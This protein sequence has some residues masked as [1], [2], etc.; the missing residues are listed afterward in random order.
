MRGARHKKRRGRDARRQRIEST[1]AL[2]V[3]A[4]VRWPRQTAAKDSAT[5]PGL[6]VR[7]GRALFLESARAATRGDRG[8]GNSDPSRVARPGRAL[9]LKR[10]GVTALGA[11]SLLRHTRK[12]RRRTR[13]NG[14]F[15]RCLAP[16][17]AAL[18]L[19]SPFPLTVLTAR[20]GI[21]NRYRGYTDSECWQL[22]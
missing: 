19:L 2:T 15:L 17:P 14:W 6:A 16:R 13:L 22:S 21:A 18:A 12:L 7:P 20:Q 1:T 8:I 9:F 11:T 4:L 5:T 3:M 10:A